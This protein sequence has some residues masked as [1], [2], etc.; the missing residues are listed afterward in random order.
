M[1][2]S[3]T[4]LFKQ[5]WPVGGSGPKLIETGDERRFR[6]ALGRFATGVTVVTTRD[7][8]GRLFGVTASSF[9]AVSLDPPMVLW[10]QATRAPSNRVFQRAPHYC[11][12]VLGADQRSL[13]DRFA[14]PAEDKFAGVPFSVGVEG[15]P[16]LHDAIAHFVCRNDYRCYGGD[17]MIFVATV[18]RYGLAPEAEPLIF[19]G[20]RYVD[21][22]TGGD[23]G[24][25]HRVASS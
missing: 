5:P 24:D 8:E 12:N 19:F 17:H 20:G 6:D 3:S 22:A 9:N 1:N 11:V 16:L 10:S 15:V 7:E 18:L 21:R 14:R 4:P 25:R 13:S 2:D 23:V